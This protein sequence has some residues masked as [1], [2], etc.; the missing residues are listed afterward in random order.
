MKRRRGPTWDSSSGLD[1]LYRAYVPVYVAPPTPQITSIS[2]NGQTVS[3][4]TDANNSTSASELSFN[5]SGAI[6]GATVSIYVDGGTTA[7]AAGT[8]AADAT[9]ITVTS[10]GTTPLSVGSHTFT[11]QQSVETSGLYL[12]SN[13]G[14]NASSQPTYTEFS[15]PPSSVN[16]RR[17]GNDRALDRCPH[18]TAQRLYDR[19]QPDRDS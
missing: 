9:T 16:Q 1:P 6:A 18:H 8:V 3:G 14:T 19:G 7:I 5:V 13:W 2:V 12:F 15:I 4:S 17:I 11:V 10:L